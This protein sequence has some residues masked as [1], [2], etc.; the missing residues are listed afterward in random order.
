MVSLVKMSEEAG[1]QFFGPDNVAIQKVRFIVVS[2]SSLFSL[3]LFQDNVS[4]EVT[5]YPDAK[6]Q[7][8]ILY[9]HSFNL[10]AFCKF[11]ILAI[12]QNLVNIVIRYISV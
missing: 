5:F 2:T 3:V 10:M 12:I 7:E 6:V 4:F 9:Y 11:R 1:I 8:V